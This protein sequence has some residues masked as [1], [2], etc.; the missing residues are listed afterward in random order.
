VSSKSTCWS[1]DL[2]TSGTT[3]S[4]K[5]DRYRNG[6]YYS[7]PSEPEAV[8]LTNFF[9][10]G[11]AQKS[12]L[13]I[14]PLRDSLFILKEDGVY[15]LSGEDSASF[16]VDLFD[17]TTRLLAP[18][19]AVVLNNQIFCLTDQGVVSI[20][21]SGVQVRSRPIET[22]ITQ[23]YAVN[24]SVIQDEA[25][26]VS[27]DTERKYIL[28]L[29]RLAGD[30][31]P[32]QAYVYN[33]FTNAWTRWDLA[34]K[35]G[36]VNPNQNDDKL[37]L[38]PTDSHYINQERKTLTFSDYVDYGFASTISVVSG[39]TLTM[40]L[41]DDI[42]VGDVIYQSSTVYSIVSAV[43]STTGEVTVSFEAAFSAGTA[44]VLKAISSRIAWVPVA[45]ANPGMLKQY[46]E[47]ALLFK[48]DFVG[49]GTLV[50]TSD[51]HASPEEETAEGTP[52]GQWGLFLWDAVPWGGSSGRR[53][54]RV[55]IP[56][57]SQRCSQLT[58]E[59]RHSTG[60]TNFQ[61][62]GLSLISNS[63]SERVAV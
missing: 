19:S 35:A 60:Y 25:F 6:I 34:K 61:L 9:F 53:P 27:Y 22:T 62:N 52:L 18:E 12:I 49:N 46:R 33:T 40:T 41:S 44:S 29:P 51:T 28:F 48:R 50:F 38:A 63:G 23:L 58:V 43:N 21:E 15:R 7:K 42:D 39:T 32:T 4:S 11:S 5:N 47:V 3:E 45:A 1:P 36:V 14:V 10:A 31:A 30:T 59:F 20:T 13:R 2:P 54:I 56:R 55:Y 8:P 37:Y 24:P 26:G 16:R 57:N 17:S